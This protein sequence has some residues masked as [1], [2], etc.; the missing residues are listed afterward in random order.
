MIIIVDFGSQT[1]HLI[2]RRIR[3]LGVSAEIVLPQDA[4]KSIL[5]YK[6]KGIILSGG[7]A[8]VYG[9]GALLIDKQILHLGIPVLGICY[10]LEVLGHLLGGEVASGTKK[11]YGPT[12]FYLK[13]ECDLFAN[14]NTHKKDFTVWMS[15]FDQ[16]VKLPEG[17]SIIGS[18]STVP[19]AAL[20]DEKKKIYG[21][22]FHPEVHHTQYGQE[23]L[24]NFVLDICRENPIIGQKKIEEIKKYLKEKINN[25]KA[26]CALSGGIDSSVTAY[27]T[28]QVIDKN[29]TCLYVDTG[30]MRSGET[31]EIRNTFKHKLKLPLVIIDAKN[32]F[33][34]ALKGVVDP[35]KKRKIIGATFIRVF[36]K[37]AKKI[38]AKI[39]VQGTI[40]PDVIE[41]QG[42]K[43]SHKIKTHHNVG[44]IPK[45]HGFQIVEPLRMF[46]KDEV[47]RI[48]R[49]LKFPQEVVMRHV[50]PG[51]GLA[52]RIIGEVNK[53]KL[54]ILNKADLIVIEE[55][56]KAGLYEKIWMSFAIFTGIKTTGVVGDERKYGETIALRIIESKDTMTA[57]WV[58]LPYDVLAKISN[59]IVT[60]VFEVVRVVY[61]ITTKPPATMEWE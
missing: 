1:T 2:G 32:E 13:K 22:M 15:H 33:L 24:R 8:S 49:E 19:I 34:K 23:I 38:G 57:D 56:K 53:E 21:I 4:L 12:H 14:W 16:V 46:Y 26:V 40:Y 42:T 6:A 59:R 28:Y 44:G 18:T 48:A 11:E 29:L 35:E 10:G 25:K 50:F 9:K 52:V 45:K 61:D 41:S 54:K 55:I 37:E 43:H 3:D 17:T 51:P 5:K 39:L 60:E 36:E 58:R 7:P 31:E 30:L 47:R 20:A 27:L